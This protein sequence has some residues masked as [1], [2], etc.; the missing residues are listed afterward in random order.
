MF[1]LGIEGNASKTLKTL[2][3]YVEPVSVSGNIHALRI[4]GIE[5]QPS[6]VMARSI[7]IMGESTAPQT[8][9]AAK[10][11]APHAKSKGVSRQ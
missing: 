2:A 9:K 5:A 1:H 10:E 6:P 11:K 4:V 7:E 8:I 3:I